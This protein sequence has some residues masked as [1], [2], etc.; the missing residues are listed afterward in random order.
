MVSEK[1]PGQGDRPPPGQ[2]FFFKDPPDTG[3]RQIRQGNQKGTRSGSEP[4]RE[5]P[6]WLSRSPMPSATWSATLSTRTLP[7]GPISASVGEVR[8]T[9]A[10]AWPG[11]YS[12]K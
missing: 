11:G 2:V 7:P 6:N 4:P 3:G 5:P 1:K 9:R 12:A 8:P 10:T